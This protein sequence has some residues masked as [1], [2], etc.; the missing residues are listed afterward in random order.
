[1]KLFKKIL[2][3]ILVLALSTALFGCV[4]GETS[5]SSAKPNPPAPTKTDSEVQIITPPENATLYYDVQV[6]VE[7]TPLP[8][9]GVYVNNEHSWSPNPSNR[10]LTG[11]GYFSLNGKTEIT[12]TGGNITSCTVRPLSAGVKTVI[13]EAS[14]KFTLKSAGNYAVE[15]NDN[16]ETAIFLFVSD[17]EKESENNFTGKVIRFE[18]GLHTTETNPHIN[19]DTVTLSSNTTVIFDEGAVVRARFVANN[20][21]NITLMGKGIIDGSAFT[22]NASTGEVKVPLDFN[23]CK[24]LKFSDFSVLDPA[25][26]CVNWYFCTDSEIDGIK[27]ITSRSNGDGISLQSCKRIKVKNCF[28]RTW[29]DSLVVKNYPKWSDRTVEGSTEDVRFENCTVWTDLA[30]SMEIGYETVGKTLKRVYFTNIT[31]LHNFHKPVISIH[32]GNNADISEVYYDTITVEDGSMGRGDAG[33]NNQLLEFSV[34][35]NPTWSN[36]HKVTALGSVNSV[37]VKNLTM[38][39]G[40]PVITLRIAGSVDRRSG[41][42]NSVHRTDG[43]SLENVWINGKKL[44]QNY[45]YLNVNEYASAQVSEGDTPKLATFNFSKTEEELNNYT[46]TAI[47]AVN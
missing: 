1:M 44:K 30:Q 4:S 5:G 11:V 3:S 40:N 41:Y 36:Q 8:L 26:W 38:L 27:I 29:D 33:A 37:S 42:G 15:L 35:Y 20:A 17:I 7:N 21:E 46:D 22:R 24:N 32:N 43:V 47:V 9:Y 6:K 10:D 13:S 12:V 34:E 19:N 2:F 28:L 14:A 23:Y 18:K 45:A 31:V 16:P 39:D 25:G